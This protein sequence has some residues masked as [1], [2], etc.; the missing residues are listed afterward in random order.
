MRCTRSPKTRCVCRERPAQTLKAHQTLAFIPLFSNIAPKDS[1]LLPDLEG[2]SDLEE[3]DTPSFQIFTDTQVADLANRFRREA[4]AYYIEAK[5][6]LVSSIS[7]VPL[8]I[9]GVMAFL[10]WN[11]FL[12][13]IRSPIYFTVLALS[14]GVCYVIYSLGMVR[15]LPV[16]LVSFEL[17]QGSSAVRVVEAG[18]NQAIEIAREQLVSNRSSA[19]RSLDVEERVFVTPQQPIPNQPNSTRPREEVELEERKSQ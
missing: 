9:Y 7:Q 19:F 1:S 12:T 10:G 13:V 3:D 8:W 6:S 11:E 16:R 17:F 14:L 15:A 18:V 2:L 4:D 5:R